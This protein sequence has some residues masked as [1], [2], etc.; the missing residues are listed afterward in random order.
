MAFVEIKN[1]SFT[2]PNCNEKALNDINFTI[3]DG[4]LCLVIGESGSGKS[5]LLKLLKK[6]IAPCGNKTGSIKI[7]SKC[8]G[9]VNQ[10]VESNIVT[11]TVSG[12]LAFALENRGESRDKI[13][14]KIAETASYFNLNGIYN[15]K[16]ES[17]SGGTKQLTALASVVIS[18]PE[19]LIFDEPASQLDP[20]SAES[21]INTVLKLNRE[22]GITVLISAHNIERLLPIADKIIYLEKGKAVVF[23]NA[24]AF[25]EFLIKNNSAFK[26]VLPSYT[27]VISSAPV[28][29]ISAKKRA[30][31]LRFRDN[32]A[33]RQSEPQ[34]ALTAKS[35]CF[36]YKRNQKNILDFLD[37]CAYKSKIN[38]IIGANGSGKTTLLKA[39]AGIIRP[40]SGKVKTNGKLCYMPQSVKAMFL[41]DTVAEELDGDKSLLKQ[42]NLFHLEN[43]N[44]FDLS[45]GEE[46]RL[47]LAKIVKAGADIILLDEPTK[48]VD[49]C[50]KET[51]ADM[52]RQLCMQGKTVVLVT[53]DLEFAGRYSDYVSFLFDGNIAAFGERRSFFGSLDMY[54]T[55]LSRLTGGKAVSIDDVKICDE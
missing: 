30:F 40:Y 28:D 54:T 46:Q 47:A 11:D 13:A 16:T 26:A 18:S 9:F 29:F 17:L 33:D 10:S 15:D 37:F 6:E 31:T 4:E 55:A 52:L 38:T 22:Q 34:K 21:F 19:L 1:L 8:I 45:G 35:I 24:K 42:F 53:H 44:P 25:A 50:F 23:E 51:L 43:R 2:Y 49:A 48:G 3:N 32:T 14:L 5:T 20:L 41:K 12:E 27:Q 39:M 36:V 7:D